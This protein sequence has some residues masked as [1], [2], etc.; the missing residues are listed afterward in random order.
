MRLGQKCLT[1]RISTYLRRSCF[2]SSRLFVFKEWDKN[3]SYFCPTQLKYSFTPCY[4]RSRICSLISEL[5]L[6]M[7]RLTSSDNARNASLSFFSNA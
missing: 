2:C 4:G 3:V 1:P 5:F 7:S 6:R